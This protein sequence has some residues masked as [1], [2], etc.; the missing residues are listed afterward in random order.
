MDKNT[1]NAV[2]DKISSGETQFFVGKYFY[3]NCGN[4]ILRRREQ[5]KNCLPKT[6]WELVANWD[7]EKDTFVFL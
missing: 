7:F 5:R 2:I 4:G 6:D 3:E 1:I